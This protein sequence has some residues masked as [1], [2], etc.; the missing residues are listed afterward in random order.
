MARNATAQDKILSRRVLVNVNRDMT[1][2]T[3]RPVWEH[4]IPILQLIFGEDE[5][6]VVDPK[7]LDEGYK[8]KASPDLLIHN[9]TQD[10]FPRP[11]ESIGLGHVFVGSPAV[12]YERLV[13]AY[14]RHKDVPIS[15]AEHVY[16]RFQEGR[17]AAVTGGATLEDLPPSQL[18]EMIKG[19]GYLYEVGYDAEKSEREA[20]KKQR[21]ELFAKSQPDLVKLATEV[22]VTLA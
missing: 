18:I 16:G 7:T 12:E 3:T 21:A 5:V 13:S 17:F 19:Y 6:T 9:K 2:A 14:G 22:G 11:S 4:E 1:T 10:A 15:N 8:Q 20:A